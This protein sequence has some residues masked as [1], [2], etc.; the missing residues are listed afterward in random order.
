MSPGMTGDARQA[1]DVRRDLRRRVLFGSVGVIL[2]LALVTLAN[3][4]TGQARQEAE[5]AK[6][7]AQ[8]A[9]VPNPGGGDAVVPSATEPLG[10][11]PAAPQ[12]A[13]AKHAPATPATPPSGTMVD[14]GRLV[15][16]DL[17]PDPNLATS[18]PRR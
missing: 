2:M 13:N 12:A 1:A 3:L 5:V 7:Q 11:V 16:P 18:S 8:A 4:L 14:G 17:Q 15:V 6:A 9:G 10:D